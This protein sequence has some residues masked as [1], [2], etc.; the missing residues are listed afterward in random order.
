MTDRAASRDLSLL[1]RDVGGNA[2]FFAREADVQDPRLVAQ[3]VAV[4]SERRRGAPEISGG[5]PDSADDV[6]LFEFLLRE[7][8][9]DS[10]SEKLVDDLLQLSVEIHFCPRAN[11]SERGGILANGNVRVWLSQNKFR[12]RGFAQDHDPN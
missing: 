5:A 8:E 11:F 2:G 4:N 7:V 10:V 1:L 12:H 3:R 9:G 6:L